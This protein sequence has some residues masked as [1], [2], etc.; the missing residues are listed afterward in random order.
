M[1]D[2]KKLAETRPFHPVLHSSI[3]TSISRF[4]DQTNFGKKLA[5]RI[6]CLKIT[7]WSRE[8]LSFDV[9]VVVDVVVVVDA[10][11]VVVVVVGS[12]SDVIVKA[13]KANFVEEKKF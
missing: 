1:P 5:P 6:F 7:F 11:V 8:S 3:K 10:V 13:K 4:D 2:P 9:G 12:G